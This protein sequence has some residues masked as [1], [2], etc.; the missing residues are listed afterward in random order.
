M[1]RDKMVDYL[2]RAL[3]VSQKSADLPAGGDRQYPRCAGHRERQRSS[4]GG[5]FLLYLQRG[6]EPSGG[7]D[8][9]F[10]GLP[11]AESVRVHQSVEQPVA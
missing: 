4:D 7:A 9:P 10:R 6:C 1:R 8:A 2:K 3:I 11:A 5:H